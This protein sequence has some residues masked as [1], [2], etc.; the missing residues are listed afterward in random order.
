MVHTIQNPLIISSVA[1]E[2]PILLAL[3]HR[4][5]TVTLDLAQLP[6]ID[7]AGLAMLLEI[8]HIA[9]VQKCHIIIQNHPEFV[10]ELCNLYKIT[11]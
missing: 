5:K 7:T 9:Q 10:V 8:K 3:M 6:R 2:L 11:L 1:T 4:S